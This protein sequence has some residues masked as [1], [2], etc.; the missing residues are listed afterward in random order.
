[1]KN[2]FNTIHEIGE[3]IRNSGLSLKD[4]DKLAYE[5]AKKNINSNDRILKLQAISVLDNYESKYGIKKKSINEDEK[6]M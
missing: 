2:S 4:K 6:V 3:I 1:M 5:W